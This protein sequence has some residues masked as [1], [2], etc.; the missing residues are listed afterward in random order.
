MSDKVRAFIDLLRGYASRERSAHFSAL[1]FVER[2]VWTQLL[3]AVIERDPVLSTFL[4]PAPLMGHGDADAR[5]SLLAAGAG[6]GGAADVAAAAVDQGMSLRDQY[7]T[8]SAFRTGAFNVLVSTSVAMEGLDI[9]ACRLVCALPLRCLCRCAA[10]LLCCCAAV[11]CR[12]V[13]VLTLSAGLGVV[14]RWQVVMFDPF[15]SLVEYIQS[16]GRCRQMNCEYRMLVSRLDVRR[17]P[18]ASHPLHSAFCLIDC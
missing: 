14:A 18:N 4:R 17:P 9:R 11:L 16:R 8:I 15:K 1:V 3:C 10:V 7:L 5:A 6:A 2:R 13:A 12:C